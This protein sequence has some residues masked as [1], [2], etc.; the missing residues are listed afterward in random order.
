MHLTKSCCVN[1]R[2][3]AKDDDSQ[4]SSATDDASSIPTWTSFKP[5][6]QSPSRSPRKAPQSPA[7]PSSSQLLPSLNRIGLKLDRSS[8]NSLEALDKAINMC[9][10]ANEV[11][12]RDDTIEKQRMRNFQKNIRPAIDIL[13][14]NSVAGSSYSMLG[15][16]KSKE[17]Y[18]PFAR[19]AASLEQA[20]PR[21][22]WMDMVERR[23]EA[24]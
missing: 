13:R 7:S 10:A 5:R 3:F 14:V 19:T 18:A 6:V 21:P 1:C 15:T 8:I 23:Q 22:L 20:S 9:A 12:Q 24:W 4:E 16:A 17:D 2:G 11:D